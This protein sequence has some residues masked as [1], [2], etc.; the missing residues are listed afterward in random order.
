MPLSD[1]RLFIDGRR[2]AIRLQEILIE[3]VGAFKKP[4]SIPV[5]LGAMTP[6]WKTHMNNQRRELNGLPAAVAA[7]WVVT[8][9]GPGAMA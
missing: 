9:Q 4:I 3:P 2:L 6:L 5:M 7:E 8:D 1:F